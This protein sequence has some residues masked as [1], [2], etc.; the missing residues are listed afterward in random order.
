[1]KTES[2]KVLGSF[3]ALAA[4]SEETGVKKTDLYK[5]PPDKIMEESGFNE[6]DYD[7]PDVKAQIE[8]FAKAYAQGQYVPPLIVRVDQATGTIFLVDGHQRRRGALLAIERGTA[9]SH[10]ECLSFR[11]NDADRVLCMLNSSEGLKL[12]PVG[13]ARGYLRLMRMGLD[14]EEIAKSVS[15]TTNHVEAMLN[16]AE[17]SRKVQEMVNQGLVSA[18]TAIEVIKKH[19]DAAESE[20]QEQLDK[21][22][23]AGKSKVTSSTMKE[24]APSRKQSVAL[25]QGAQKLVSGLKANPKTA[26]IFEKLGKIN[27]VDLEGEKV[28]VDASFLIELMSVFSKLEAAQNKQ[29][30]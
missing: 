4:N 28:E 15:K 3:K 8:T 14:V 13:I 25:Y 6:R 19:G 10:L 9:I 30:K 22:Q 7:D 20:L 2:K 16:L 1:M 27:E 17:A 26:V 23:S 11:G 29:D 12:K 18:T 5:I 24:W 21:A